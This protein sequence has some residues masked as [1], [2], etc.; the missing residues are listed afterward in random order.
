MP[1]PT[2]LINGYRLTPAQTIAVRMAVSDLYIETERN[3]DA[4]GRDD[5]AAPR[6]TRIKTF[7]AASREIL[8][9][10]AKERYIRPPCEKKLKAPI[11]AISLVEGSHVR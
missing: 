11:G 2:I 1:E 7:Q 8:T 5:I 4:L 6:R 9:I 3:P 10:M